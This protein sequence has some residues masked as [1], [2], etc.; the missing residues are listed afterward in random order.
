MNITP[1]T[2]C[3]VARFRFSRFLA[4]GLAVLFASCGAEETTSA[5]EPLNACELFTDAD[6]QMLLGEPAVKSSDR[7]PM[8]R[9]SEDGKSW[10]SMCGYNGT[11]SDRAISITV[12]YG[13]TATP[14]KTSDALF[15]EL[16]RAAAAMNED[17]LKWKQRLRAVSGIGDVAAWDP[18]L[19]TLTAYWK[20]YQLV[21]LSGP[22][23]K[24]SD[25]TDLER[26][27]TMLSQVVEKL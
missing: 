1:R 4:A 6:A 27:K 3:L 20:Q 10:F 22:L 15:D 7:Y 2:I 14:P 5:V 8:G 12:R 17:P 16:A 25:E 21:A 19:G 18:E 11:T 26:A 23:T 13:V 9:A 24:N